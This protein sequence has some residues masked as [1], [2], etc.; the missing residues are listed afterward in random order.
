ML[1]GIPIVTTPV[2]SITEVL[3][4]EKSALIVAP[5]DCAA[6]AH[7]M[8]RLLD[9]PA[10]GDR[11]CAAARATALARYTRESMLDAMQ[12]IFELVTHARSA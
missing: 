4:H 9:E 1:A 12:R 7:A 5:E 11:L 10:L 6:L 8:Q 2:G 3:E